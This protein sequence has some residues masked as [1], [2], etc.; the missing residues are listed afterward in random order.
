MKW[1]VLKD[2][3]PVLATSALEGAAF[4]KNIEARIVRQTE[5]KKML[6]STVFLGL[7]HNHSGVGDP[8]LF[9]TMIFIDGEEQYCNRCS[10]WK[11]AEEMH[12]DALQ[13]AMK[14]RR[15]LIIRDTDPFS[16]SDEPT[17]IPDDH[18]SI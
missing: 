14:D 8:I 12:K 15:V 11:Q 4:M 16:T 18:A 3:V 10:T 1:Y 6:I 13:W 7:D 5:N 17:S 2:R 9:E